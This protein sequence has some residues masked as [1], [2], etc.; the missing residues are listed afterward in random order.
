MMASCIPAFPTDVFNVLGAGDGFAAGFLSGWLR[1]SSLLDAGK[2]GN[3]CGSLVVSRH[4]CAPAMPR[5]TE[6]AAFLDRAETIK[7][8]HDDPQIVH[9]HRTTTGRTRRPRIFC[10]RLRSPPPIRGY[11]G[12][13]QW[14][15][16]ADRQVQAADR[17]RA[18][19]MPPE[20]S[21]AIV[22]DRYGFDALDRPDGQRPLA[23]APGRSGGNRPLEFEAGRNLHSALRTWPA[24]HVIKCLV[25]YSAGDP[26]ELRGP[27]ER[28][29]VN[30]A[31]RC[32]FHRSSLAAGGHPAGFR[33][34]SGSVVS[35]GRG[36]V[37]DRLA[38]GLVEI[39]AAS[40]DDAWSAIAKVILRYD[41]QCG[42]VVV[43]GY[44]RPEGELF[45]AF[46]SAIRSRAAVGF[47]IG[48]SVWRQPAADWFA[49]KIDDAAAID[50]ISRQYGS[51]LNGWLRSDAASIS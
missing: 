10:A 51:V 40:N 23:C 32:I 3:A 30:L 14:R 33:N 36:F 19:A 24:E 21:G 17:A 35:R 2:F 41:P 44:D 12:I 50:Q 16:G 43:L 22:D 15:R 4:G 49:D 26:N 6:L 27:A 34:R 38:P 47:A 48:R 7:R 29:A 46:E 18:V 11:D 45:S 8:P 9:L 42:G 25:S 13:Q 31:G 28:S 1:N 37:S 20:H 39:A 5:S